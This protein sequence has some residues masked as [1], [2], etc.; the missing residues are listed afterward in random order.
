[1]PEMYYDNAGNYTGNS[2]AGT[3]GNWTR[4]GGGAANNP[5]SPNSQSNAYNL[6]SR[7]AESNLASMPYNQSVADLVNA[8]NRSAQ[9]AANAARLGPAGQAVQTQLL[10]NAGA[11]AA[12]QVSPSTISMLQQGAAER[13]VAGG[14]GPNS[15][16]MN[17]SY[18]RALGLTSEG[19]QQQALGNYATLTNLNPGAPIYSAG[20]NLVTPG[21]YASVANSQ[22]GTGGGSAPRVSFPSGV[23]GAAPVTGTSPTGGYGAGYPSPAMSADEWDY[24]LGFGDGG[25][26]SPGA[27]A[28]LVPADTYV[29][30]FTG[31]ASNT[32]GL[33]TYFG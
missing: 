1:M 22:T 7:T 30:P 4:P 28:G 33:D 21:Q 3:I 18:L 6:A 17:A 31:Q 23:G 20:T 29:D 19:L 27:E 10:G 11:E 13:G 8:A 14:F 5:Y 15:P 26:G 32:Y 9:T 12:G 2:A 16:N 24:A 25:G